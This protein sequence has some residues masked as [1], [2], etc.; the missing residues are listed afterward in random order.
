MLTIL[1]Y[2]FIA[3]VAIELLQYIIL[4]GPLSF[5]SN[6]LPK[7][8]SEFDPVSV[9]V[10]VKDQ[11]KNLV[12]FLSKLKDQQYPQFQIVLINNASEDNSLDI[13]EQFTL[14]NK[15]VKLVNVVNNEAFWGN[16]KYAL[17]L[18]IK[19][20]QFDRLVFIE[21]QGMPDSTNWLLSLVS[22][23]STTKKIV[24]G[25]TKIE[26]KKRSLINQLI[27]YQNVTKT[28]DLFA[29]AKVGK[30]LYGN[31]LNQG[32][33]KSLFYKVNGFIKFMKTPYSDEYAFISQI[34]NNNNVAIS[35]DTESFTTKK[36]PN[37]SSY[38][39]SELKKSNLLL[40]EASIGS[41]LKLRF[42]NLCHFLFYALSIILSSFL[43]NWEIV[44][45]LILLRFIIVFIYKAKM[46]K[47]FEVKD[48]IWVLPI[49]EIIHIFM[50]TIY[51]VRQF[52]TRKKFETYN[53]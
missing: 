46:F 7:R 44:V 51:S 48:L 6:F 50:I 21:P 24:L 30:P 15:N 23:F 52:I 10:Y 43:F 38:W 53:S 1:F 12:D 8:Y 42:F 32:Y 49:L 33:D 31:A 20:A 36:V 5:S 18:G 16:K 2:L 34:G 4:Y 26:K 37:K 9:I 11:E 13:L 29:W 41:Q 22:C 14:E 19:V 47:K 45:G 17:T 35:L 40:K 3:V 28:I 27:R 39:T 25:Y